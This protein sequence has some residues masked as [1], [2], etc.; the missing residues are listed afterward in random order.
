MK[1]VALSPS[2]DP[3]LV[4]RPDPRPAADEIVI[5]LRAICGSDLPLHSSSGPCPRTGDSWPCLAVPP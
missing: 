4:D 5:P 3:E 2:R 1:A